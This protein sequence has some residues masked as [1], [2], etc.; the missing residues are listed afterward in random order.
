VESD[1][2]TGAAD[3]LRAAREMAK[4]LIEI[5][6]SLKNDL[7]QP[8]RMG[9]GIHI[10]HVI[11]GDMGYAQVRSIT[12]IGDAVNTASRLEAL[13]KEF[14]SQLIVS[15]DV[16][17]RAGMD[18]SSIPKKTVEVRGRAEPLDVYILEDAIKLP[19]GE[20]VSA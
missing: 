7:P 6:I 13:N 17:A 9:I 4:G 5:N 11:V 15:H 8:L 1:A 16:V 12:A 14:G 2:A 10:G 18:F 3:S 19:V 20:A